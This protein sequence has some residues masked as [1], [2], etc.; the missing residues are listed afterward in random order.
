MEQ[1]LII[2]SVLLWIGLLFNFLLILALT[3]RLSRSHGTG[4]EPE[5]LKPGTIAPAFQAKSLDGKDVT[6]SQYKGKTVAFLFVGPGCVPCREFM[7]YFIEL[8]PDVQKR[9]IELALVSESSADAMQEYL[10]EYKLDL[11]VLIAPSGDGK[12]S[13][14]LD[15]YKVSGTPSYCL[16]SPDG[17]V[18]AAGY[19]GLK[20]D[21]FREQV[22]RV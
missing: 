8:I 10:K 18:L 6:E 3:R 11:P 14:F 19:P 17:K 7:P 12:L 22:L 9:G 21:A 15:D 1:I 2:S 5:S 20:A 13:K 4:E 16:V